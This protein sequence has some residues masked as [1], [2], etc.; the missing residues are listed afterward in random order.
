MNRLYLLNNRVF[1]Y[2]ITIAFV[3][4]FINFLVISAGHFNE[5]AY[6]LFIYVENLIQGNGISFYPGGP[7]A[8]GATDFLWFLMLSALSYLGLDVGISAMLLNSL[9]VL[10]IS[11]I[12]INEI[13]TSDIKNNRYKIFLYPLAIFWILQVPLW[14]ALG[15]F[16]VFLYMAIVLL[17]FL[18]IINKMVL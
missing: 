10:I 3:Y 13:Q 16:S 6:I 12:I 15:G 1:F 9:G 2:S 18:T 5:D 8:E 14:A 17:A 11:A 7:H 4:F